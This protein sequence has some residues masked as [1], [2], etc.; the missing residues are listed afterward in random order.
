M[1]LSVIIPSYNEAK[2]LPT[3]IGRILRVKLGFKK[4]IVIVD[5]GSNDNTQ[6]VLNKFKDKR[7]IKVLV[8][9]KNLGKGT[10]II[11]ALK[12]VSGDLILIQDADL[13]YNPTDIP[14]L[15]EPFKNKS[16]QVV[17]GSRVL[18]KNPISHWTYNLGG[19]FVTMVTNFLY[20]THITDEPTGY[21]VFRSKL[22]KKIKLNSHR[23]EFC[24]EITAKV[25]KLKIKI[26]EV[27]IS[28]K[29]RSVKEK[30]IKWHDGFS[31]IYYLFKYRFIN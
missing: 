3:I 18:S 1:K 17:Y 21:K 7:E 25:S 31:A 30:K 10:S 11:K 6:I 12:V 26:V 13:E 14:R 9:K 15:L 2:T 22:L 8:N 24:P 5:D 16:T 19:R 29:P 23:F 20:N 28:Y 4:E 27:P